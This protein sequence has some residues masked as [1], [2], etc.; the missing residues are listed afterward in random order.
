M[1]FYSDEQAAE[2]GLTLPGAPAA[3]PGQPS[4]GG[5]PRFYTDEEALKLGAAL[6]MG[7]GEAF[8]RSFYRHATLG[9]SPGASRAKEEQ[10]AREHPYIDMASAVPAFVGQTMLL[11]PAAAALKGVEGVNALATAARGAGRAIEV[12]LLPNTEART[13]LQSTRTGAKVGGVYS[14]LETAGSDL[15][16][17]DKSWGETLRDTTLAGGLGTAGGAVLGGAGHGAS[18]LIGAAANRVMPELAG[19]REAANAPGTQGARDVMRQLGY[20]K[21][22]I[23]EL[24]AARAAL[25]DPELAHIY[26]DK[27]LPEVMET[28]PLKADPNTG[29]LRANPRIVPNLRDFAQDAANTG[30]VGRMEALDNYGRRRSE[31]AG[32]LQA[33]ID[34]LTAPH[35]PAPAELDTALGRLSGRPAPEPTELPSFIDQH[36]GS[37]AR[38]TDQAAA[39]VAKAAFDRRFENMRKQPLIMTTEMGELA[40]HSK[41]FRNAVEGAAESAAIDK[42]AAAVAGG[43]APSRDAGAMKR[44]LTGVKDANGDTVQ[45]ISPSDMLKIHHELVLGANSARAAGD[46]A[47]E[48]NALRLKGVFSDWMEKNFSGSGSAKNLMGDYSIFKSMLEASDHAGNLSLAGRSPKDLAALTFLENATNAHRQATQAVEN[49]TRRYQAAQQRAA[50]GDIAPSTAAKMRTTLDD[51]VRAQDARAGVLDEFRKAWG[52]SLKERLAG[53]KNPDNMVREALTPAGQQRLGDALG[54]AE[55][56]PFLNKLFAMEARN[57]ATATPLN[58]AP[59]HPG[60]RF[61]QQMSRAGRDDAVEAYR[62]ARQAKILSDL[63]TATS[64]SGRSAVVDKLLT[65]AGANHAVEVFGGQR[66]G[67]LMEHLL[68]MRARDVAMKMPLNPGANHPGVDFFSRA[69]QMEQGGK[70]A[71]AAAFRNARGEMYKNAIS[72]ASSS[73]AAGVNSIID[74]MLTQAGK[75]EILKTFGDVEGRKFIESLYSKQAQAAM[76]KTLFGGPDTA[77]KLARNKKTDS[78]MDAVHGVLHLRPLQT[79]KALG[80]IGSAAYKQQRADQVNRLLSAQGPDEVKA[81]IDAVLANE[82]LRRTANPVVRNPVLRSIGPVGA[83]PVLTGTQQP[84]QRRRQSGAPPAPPQR[85][86]A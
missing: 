60:V 30:G 40:Q 81:I 67:A 79:V 84:Q 3:A 83:A 86:N 26:A 66:G 28:R 51:A 71:V 12:G 6:P 56:Q 22:G 61:F 69:L 10:A 34:R 9:L 63:N 20:D 57:Q 19:V 62:H 41:A 5:A 82:Q 54:Q 42:A 77:Y 46:Q 36:F 15:T 35:A 27:N 32:K 11:G 49:L 18:R 17:P 33:E 72:Q 48:R 65:N 4:A 85:A 80:E 16:N 70:P 2:L 76:S 38:D 44:W 58:A 13:A 45:I 52:E 59:N 21:F 64:D 43:R 8:A 68:Q 75:S 55:A 24:K 25:D 7:A 31:M 47:A 1:A 37:G 23:E 29:E 53:A 78:L 74:K 14:G 50:A 39:D 73:T